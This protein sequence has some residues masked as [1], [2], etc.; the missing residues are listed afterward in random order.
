MDGIDGRL[1]GGGVAGAKPEMQTAALRTISKGQDRL[2]ANK[3][4]QSKKS[5]TS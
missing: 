5:S 1:E 2:E 3:T 4:E